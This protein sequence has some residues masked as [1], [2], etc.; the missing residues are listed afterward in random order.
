MINM[1]FFI[2]ETNIFYSI[3]LKM[4]TIIFRNTQNALKVVKSDVQ[5]ILQGMLSVISYQDWYYYCI[6]YLKGCINM[7]L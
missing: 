3:F 7:V 1:I 5:K 6:M 4:S 2:C